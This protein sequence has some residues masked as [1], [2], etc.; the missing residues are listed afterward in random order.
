MDEDDLSNFLDME[1]NF[2][3]DDFISQLPEDLEVRVCV[4]VCVCVCVLLYK[5]VNLIFSCL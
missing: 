1:S 5:C 3:A 4:C 2:S